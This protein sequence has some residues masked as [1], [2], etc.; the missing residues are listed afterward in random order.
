AALARYAG[1]G[2]QVDRLAGRGRRHGDLARKV[3]DVG[4]GLVDTGG[5][6]GG[7]DAGSFGSAPDHRLG[8]AGRLFLGVQ[9]LGVRLAVG[10]GQSAARS[11]DAL[12]PAVTVGADQRAVRAFG[13]SKS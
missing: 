2:A 10:R 5:D 12:S 7:G 4:L 9:R 13:K 3:H 11:S 1:R 8:A 6:V